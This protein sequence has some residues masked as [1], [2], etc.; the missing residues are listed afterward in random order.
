MP[1]ALL[2]L[3]ELRDGLLVPELNKQF[4]LIHGM[5][6]VLSKLLPVPELSN[7]LN[8]CIRGLND[9]QTSSTAGVCVVINGVIKLRG[10][11]LKPH[12]SDLV[13]GFYSAMPAIKHEQTMNGTLH[14][15][16]SLATH[17]LIPVV[18]ELLLAPQPHSPELIKTLQVLAKDE[19]LVLDFIEHLMDVINNSQLYDEE[20][21]DGKG[22][23]V[24]VP[25]ARA[26]AAT[27]S[28]GE[29][30]A[31]EEMQDVVSE[32]YP[33]ICGT[34]LL[35]FGTTVGCVPKK[36]SLAPEEQPPAEAEKGKKKAPS[37]SIPT[38]ATIDSTEQAY[39]SLTA[40]VTCSKDRRFSDVLVRERANFSSEATWVAGLTNFA[41]TVAKTQTDEMR[42]I[43]GF[44]LPYVR[45]NY[46]GQKIA[47]AA[48]LSEFV[49]HCNGDFELLDKLVST[50]LA[51]LID[52]PLKIHALRGLGNITSN[53][54]EQANK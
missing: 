42:G 18:N 22:P 1:E 21:A 24:R 36:M 33:R 39:A 6:Q 13:R 16:R 11:D 54:K 35:R 32:H 44:L 28:L 7:L 40:L 30:M 23:L 48:I 45:G 2:P 34:L 38:G 15:V 26:M 37:K 29:I 50:L 53:G 3:K 20:Q 12:V 14:A 5:A 47:A 49:N 17:H 4:G 19:N 41:A 31:I 52:P 8:G 46:V 43:F 51:A 27:A 25:V 10:A 9:T